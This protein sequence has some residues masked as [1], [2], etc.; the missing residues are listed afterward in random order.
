MEVKLTQ[1]EYEK[2]QRQIAKL[3]ALEAGGVD[4]WDW[5]D[6]SLNGWHKENAYDE[7]ID[8]LVYEFSEAVNELGIEADVDFPGGYECGANVTMPSSEDEAKTFINLVIKKYK[9]FEG[10][11]NAS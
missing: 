6:E 7:L 1:A 2:M 9:E 4:N 10:E 5:Y 11:H 8:D 3:N